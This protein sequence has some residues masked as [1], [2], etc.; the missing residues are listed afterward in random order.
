MPVLVV[1]LITCILLE[2]TKVFGYGAQLSPNVRKVL[3]EY[4]DRTAKNRTKSQMTIII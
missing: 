3:E 4:E 2:V 1:G